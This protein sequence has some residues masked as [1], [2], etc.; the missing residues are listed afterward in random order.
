MSAGRIWIVARHALQEALRRRVLLVVIV[1]TAVFGALYAWGCSELFQDVDQFRDNDTGLDPTAL[2]GSTIVGLAMFGGLFLGVVLAT[3]LTAGAVRGDAERGLLQ[4]LIVR[5][6]TRTEYLVGR[7]LAAASVSALYVLIVY[8]GAVVVTGLIGDWWPAHVVAVG[9]RLAGG[10]V[11]IAGLALLGSVFLGATANGIL[12]LMTYG[13]GLLAGLLG[14]I[15]DAI[16]SP[17]LQHIAST[18]SWVLPFEALYR[19]ALRLLVRD[20][21]GVTG[22]LVQLGPLGGSHDAGP[23][24][25]P[26]AIAYLLGVLA[27][28]TFAFARRDV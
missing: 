20:V 16:P 18:A 3:F 26:W 2:A 19:D 4:P 1:L 22:A 9:L 10:A 11:L 17:T 13:M 5:P 14:A 21:P 7:F 12:L 8:F 28:A 27:L 23:L 15:G 25:V 6:L 24:L